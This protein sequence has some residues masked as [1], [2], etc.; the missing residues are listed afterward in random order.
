MSQT[1]S[2]AANCDGENLF[3]PYYL[4]NIMHSYSFF[5]ILPMLTSLAS[6]A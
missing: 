4:V 1:W 5:I 3:V 6:P 2:S